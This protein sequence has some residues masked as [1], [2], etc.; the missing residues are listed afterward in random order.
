VFALGLAI[1]LG[2]CA[3]SKSAS[4]RQAE[5]AARLLAED[6]ETCAKVRNGGPTLSNQDCVQFA[7]RYRQM[8]AEPGPT[9]L[10][11][12]SRAFINDV[13]A[14]AKLMASTPGLTDGNCLEKMLAD[15]RAARAE[16]QRQIAARADAAGAFFGGQA[17]QDAT[18]RNRK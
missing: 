15:R 4:E 3:A 5:D 12:P 13:G 10:E 14:C 8:A 9:M 11:S 2:A 16:Q 17:L 6:S 18:S 1:P 7:V